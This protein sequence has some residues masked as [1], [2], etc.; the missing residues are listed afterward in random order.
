[1]TN[2]ATAWSAPAVKPI[3]HEALKKAEIRATHQKAL[4]DM[5]IQNLACTVFEAQQ[6]IK[7]A[8]SMLARNTLPSVVLDHLAFDRYGFAMLQRLKA[9]D[10]LLA[11]AKA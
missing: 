3:S 9:R 10:H 5:L 1:M 11:L 6:Y 7:T 8:L 4:Q 2:I